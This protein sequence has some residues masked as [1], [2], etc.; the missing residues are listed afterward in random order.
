MSTFD[1]STGSD[2]MSSRL[3]LIDGD[4]ANMYGSPVVYNEN[5]M[6]TY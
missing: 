2:S 6:T 1:S 3:S 5:R 4:F